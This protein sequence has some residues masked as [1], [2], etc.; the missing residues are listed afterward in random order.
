MCIQCYH[1]VS[2]LLPAKESF[3]VEFVIVLCL[4]FAER[5]TLCKVQCINIYRQR[6]STSTTQEHFLY[7]INIMLLV[8]KKYITVAG[9]TEETACICHLLPLIRPLTH[10]N[11]WPTV[12]AHEVSSTPQLIPRKQL[13]PHDLVKITNKCYFWQ[14]NNSFIK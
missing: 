3:S 1:C 9:T 8:W 7:S 14:R 10:Q 11:L 5:A 2:N 6:F 4:L 13:L 12:G